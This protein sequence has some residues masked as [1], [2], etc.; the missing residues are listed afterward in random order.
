VTIAEKSA[1]V[2]PSNREVNSVLRRARA[3]TSARM[4]G[5]LLFKA[6]KFMEACA[7]YNEGLDHDPNNSVLL[8]NRAACRSKLGQYEKA[9]E[10][11]DAAL[12]LNPCYSKA[13]LRRAYCNAKVI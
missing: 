12:Q 3:V 7:V 8:C 6:S 4:S 5:N 1:R 13:K 2:D 10:D 11:C 9:I